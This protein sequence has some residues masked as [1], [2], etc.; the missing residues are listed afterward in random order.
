MCSG[1]A[2]CQQKNL[3]G[4]PGVI[5][6]FKVKIWLEKNGDLLLSS[7]QIEL[8]RKIRDCGSLYKATKELSMSYRAA[9]GKIKTSEKK[10]GRKFVQTEGR[11]KP[12]LLT[13]DGQELLERFDEFQKEVLDSATEVY[14][15]YFPKNLG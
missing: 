2:D 7:G 8:L 6:G 9:W 11:V 4:Q 13:N 5:M 14:K 1:I 10:L 12:L 3:V 15:K